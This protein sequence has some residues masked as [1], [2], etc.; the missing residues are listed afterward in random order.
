MVSA[1]IKASDSVCIS[2]EPGNVWEASSALNG[3]AAQAGLAF[4]AQ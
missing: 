4:H 2:I 3:M 1:K